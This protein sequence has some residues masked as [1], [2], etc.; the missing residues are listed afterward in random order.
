MN[1][2]LITECTLRICQALQIGK[3]STAKFKS[4]APQDLKVTLRTIGLLRFVE[5]PSSSRWCVILKYFYT[6]YVASL[7][8]SKPFFFTLDSFWIARATLI[9]NT[10]VQWAVHGA[11]KIWKTAHCVLETSRKEVDGVVRQSLWT[12]QA[13]TV[14]IAT[15]LKLTVTGQLS[16]QN[17]TKGIGIVFDQGTVN[18]FW[19]WRAL[20]LKQKDY[21]EI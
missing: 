19:I 20:P 8:L 1:L 17:I 18:T 21:H 14:H 4:C 13:S 6:V 5:V 16:L 11:R 3:I 7:A 15:I 9:V 2:G 10:A 12:R